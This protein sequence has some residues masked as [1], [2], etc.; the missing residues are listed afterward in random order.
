MSKPTRPPPPHPAQPGYKKQRR[1]YRVERLP[2]PIRA[3]VDA[4]L[5]QGK[6]YRDIQKEVQAAGEK[7][8]HGAIS[9]YWRNR[10]E[11]HSRWLAWVT[12]QAAGL[13]QAL[14]QTGESDEAVLVRKLLI[15][16]VLA[17]MQDAFPEIKF[18]DLVRES[19]EMVKVTRDL[20]SKG[21]AAEQ[22]MSLAERQRRM[23]EIYGWP[24]EE[25]E[26]LDRPDAEAKADT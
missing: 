24:E 21:L 12:A 22:P 14:H 16:Q 11:P 17:R 19:R 18:F 10:W 7:I 2:E 13:A 4:G 26:A 1:V 5:R 3:L 25:L 6:S 8:S 23:R 15:G 9:G 20:P